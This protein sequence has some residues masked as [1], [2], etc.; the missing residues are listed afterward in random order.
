MS[1]TQWALDPTHSELQFKV[2]HLMI[3]TVTGSF[4]SFTARVETDGENFENAKI[5][6]S[7]EVNSIDSGN[8]QRDAHLKSA[9][10]FEADK[11]PTLTFSSTKLEKKDEENYLLYG[12]LNIKG[13][14]KPVVIPTEFGG[15]AKDPWGNNKVGFTLNGKINRK[16]W[17]LNWNATLEAGGVLVSEEV[18]II[19]EVQFVKQA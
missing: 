10:F 15:L 6:F 14:I 8:E 16:D 2:K 7:A 4:K 18:K 17:D 11:F 3:T 12:N 13:V 19:A 1:K 9:D 5:E